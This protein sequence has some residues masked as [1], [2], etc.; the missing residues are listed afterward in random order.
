MLESGRS[1]QPFA[2]RTETTVGIAFTRGRDDGAAAVVAASGMAPGV[3]PALARDTTSRA[4]LARMSM[5]AVQP[6]TLIAGNSMTLMDGCTVNMH[7]LWVRDKTGVNAL[8]ADS[9]VH[10]PY[11]FDACRD[12]STVGWYSGPLNLGELSHELRLPAPNSTRPAAMTRRTTSSSP[13]RLLAR[14]LAWR[15]CRSPPLRVPA[16]PGGVRPL[17]PYRQPPE[18]THQ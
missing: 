14:F 5:A 18:G 2:L 4:G 10:D 12:K 8:T 7:A 16:D 17:V 11:L 9:G 15:A 13:T 3:G 6:L 1:P